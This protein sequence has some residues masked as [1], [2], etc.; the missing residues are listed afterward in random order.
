MTSAPILQYPETQRTS[1]ID[2]QN[3]IPD[4]YRWLENYD[5]NH[6]AAHQKWIAEQN[7]LT[8]SFINTCTFKDKIYQKLQE[9][10]NYP[11]F[12]TPFVEGRQL[13]D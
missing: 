7:N 5:S 13:L 3:G 10:Q 1:F 11:K 12:G 8:N 6:T 4:P 9:G 2:Q